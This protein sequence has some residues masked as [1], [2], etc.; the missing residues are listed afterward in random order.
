MFKGAVV[1][2][3]VIFSRQYLYSDVLLRRVVNILWLRSLF[4]INLVGISESLQ[5]M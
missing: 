4:C 1:V 3:L 5:L 2:Y